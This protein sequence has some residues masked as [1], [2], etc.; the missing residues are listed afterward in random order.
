MA[1]GRALMNDPDLIWSMSR[2]PPWTQ[3]RP[4]GGAV[5]GTRDQAAGKTGIMVT[6]DLRMVRVHRPVFEILDGELTP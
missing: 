2:P 3:T 5:A 4:A 6:H 1:I